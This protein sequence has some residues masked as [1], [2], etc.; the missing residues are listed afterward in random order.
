MELMKNSD[1][2]TDSSNEFPTIEEWVASKDNFRVVGLGYERPF[3]LVHHRSC[4]AS[5]VHYH[6]ENA[7]PHLVS[8]EL[9][10]RLPPGRIDRSNHEK[11]QDIESLLIKETL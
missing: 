4:N 9:T 6:R 1:Y 2:S 11:G 10:K 7:A 3:P 5:L 8:I